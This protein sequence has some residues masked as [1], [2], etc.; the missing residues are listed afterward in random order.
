[1][2]NSKRAVA[3]RGGVGESSNGSAVEMD[4]DQGEEP[5]GLPVAGPEDLVVPV[6]VLPAEPLG[7]VDP[8]EGGEEAGLQPLA[9]LAEQLAG[10]VDV[11]L[12]GELPERAAGG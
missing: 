8:A 11:Q 7:G 6:G 10:V 12:L 4:A 9:L 1:M 3:W 5:A 2:R